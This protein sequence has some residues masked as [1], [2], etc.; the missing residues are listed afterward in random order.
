MLRLGEQIGGN[1]GGIALAIGH[2]QNL[3]RACDHIDGNQPKDLLFRLGN[4]GIPR[5]H[6]LIHLGDALGSIGQCRHCL[7]TAHL[8][9]AVHARDLGGR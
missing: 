1:M 8:E 7:G 6:D 5:P 3:R 4:K 9:D 2:H